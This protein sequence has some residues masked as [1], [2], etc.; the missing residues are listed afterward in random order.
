MFPVRGATF[1]AA[2]WRKIDILGDDI[3]FRFGLMMF[4]DL[5][6]LEVDALGVRHQ[7]VTRARLEPALRADV[8][9]DV[10]VH[11]LDVVVEAGQ[12]D[13][14]VRTLFARVLSRRTSGFGIGRGVFSLHSTLNI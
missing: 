3:D 14:D 13:G 10:V 6:D 2:S 4:Q 1:S 9:A 7:P 5:P 12:A 8:L 11:D